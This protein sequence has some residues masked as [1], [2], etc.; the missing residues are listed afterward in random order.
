VVSPV[1]EDEKNG[2]F[3]IISFYAKRARGLMARY[4]IDHRIDT[5]EGL[6]AFDLE[7]Y[8]FAPKVSTP[9]QPVFRRLEKH[10]PSKG[11]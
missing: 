1:F 2:A 3:K 9:L 5:P 4:V 7:G 8:Q 6:T 10:Q 11:A